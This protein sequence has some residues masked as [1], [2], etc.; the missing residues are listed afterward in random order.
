MLVQFKRYFTLQVILE[1]PVQISLHQSV[2]FELIFKYKR[3]TINS[4]LLILLTS[5]SAKA[6]FKR[7]LVPFE[8]KKM[9]LIKVKKASQSGQFMGLSQGFI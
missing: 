8:V 7:D 5:P 9:L 6:S 1:N 2:L 3:L 4:L